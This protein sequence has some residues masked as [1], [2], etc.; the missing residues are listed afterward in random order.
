[1]DC[2]VTLG[3]G[4][5]LFVCNLTL[6]GHDRVL[7]KRFVGPGKVLQF[8]IS[9]RGG[10]LFRVNV[11]IVIIGL[12]FDLLISVGQINHHRPCIVQLIV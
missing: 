3:R 6:L 10:T 4:R 8:F 5:R 1:M 9:K 2:T 12:W 7:K 11:S